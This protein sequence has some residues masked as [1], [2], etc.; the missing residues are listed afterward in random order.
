[1]R[2]GTLPA[3]EHPPPDEGDGEGVGG[4]G[5]RE[6]S[7]APMSTPAPWGRDT[8]RWSAGGAPEDVPASMA[9]LPARSAHVKVR[10]P[11]SE[12]SAS[13]GSAVMMEV[14][15]AYPPCTTQYL[16]TTEAVGWV[17]M[18]PIEDPQKME[19]LMAGLL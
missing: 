12:R 16:T 1:M 9:E 5:A 18:L 19:F 13:F 4:G 11:L 7:K 3:W 6:N 17:W 14:P 15:P 8:P 2:D 10:P